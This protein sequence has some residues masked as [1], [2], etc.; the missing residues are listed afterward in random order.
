MEMLIKNH[1]IFEDN[2]VLTS[3]QLNQLHKYLDQQ[4]RLTRSCLIGSGIAC[5]LEIAVETGNELTITIKEGMGISSDGYLIK[6]CPASGFCTT[7]QFRNYTLPKGVVYTP[8]QDEKFKQNVYLYE[9]L[10]SDAQ[11]DE[12]EIVRPLTDIPGG[13]ENKAVILFLE[14]LDNDLKSCLGKSCDELGVDRIFNLRKLLIDADDL[15]EINGNTINDQP[16][17]YSWWSYRAASR[18]QGGDRSL[19]ADR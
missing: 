9:L 13:L 1:P 12:N 4:N 18:E 14:C 16:D 10:T 11:I 15:L 5:G 8:F 6:V 7:V 19:T 17:N 3:G 2:Q